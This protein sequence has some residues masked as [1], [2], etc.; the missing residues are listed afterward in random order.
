M[1]TTQPNPGHECGVCVCACTCVLCV[2]A[3]VQCVC[4]EYAHVRVVLCVCMC[5]LYCV[6]VCLWCDLCVNVV[7]S[8]AE[9][10]CP[11]CICREVGVQHPH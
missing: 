6:C 2:C 11:V 1:N 10:H 3:R 4:G 8:A 7:L 5:V 9:S